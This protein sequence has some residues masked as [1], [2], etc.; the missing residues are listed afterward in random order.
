VRGVTGIDGSAENWAIRERPCRLVG[1]A[2]ML[3]W[4]DGDGDEG[5]V[6]RCNEWDDL[7][8][9]RVR[10]GAA[11]AAGLR[12][13]LLPARSEQPGDSNGDDLVCR[14]LPRPRDAPGVVTAMT[15]SL[16]PFPPVMCGRFLLKRSE[17]KEAFFQRLASV[18]DMEE[19]HVAAYEG[20]ASKLNSL[21]EAACYIGSASKQ[22]ERKACPTLSDK[23]R[24]SACSASLANLLDQSGRTPLHHAAR[25]GNND[26]IE[27]L[28]DAKAD[29]LLKGKDGITPLDVALM[30]SKLDDVGLELM[31]GAPAEEVEGS[32]GNHHY[33][34]CSAVIAA[35]DDAN[36]QIWEQGWPKTGNGFTLRPEY[37]KQSSLMPESLVCDSRG[38][39]GLLGEVATPDADVA[40]D[41]NLSA[42]WSADQQRRSANQST[43]IEELVQIEDTSVDELKTYEASVREMKKL[44]QA[45]K[46]TFI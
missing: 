46:V 29:P 34:H 11:V 24:T 19:I 27:L 25:N 9:E 30:S 14:F 6:D 35:V 23:Q 26:C 20:D 13:A 32:V 38:V 37:Q 15:V 17:G 33:S 28:L 41:E 5:D 45:L 18:S 42:K 31:R 8:A 12:R 40:M 43:L 39:Y 4:A 1:E 16:T 10:W 36:G 22:K 3:E 21:L 44:R 2:A 7:D